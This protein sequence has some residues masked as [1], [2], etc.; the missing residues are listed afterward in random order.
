MC[1]ECI[2]LLR[3]FAEF[4]DMSAVAEIF[5]KKYVKNKALNKEQKTIEQSI[6]INEGR[7]VEQT[8]IESLHLGEDDLAFEYSSNELKTENV[9]SDI[10][11]NCM[12][13]LLNVDSAEMDSNTTT[14]VVDL[15]IERDYDISD[16]GENTIQITLQS[17][18]LSEIRCYRVFSQEV[19]KKAHDIT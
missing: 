8:Y 16:T 13:E 12:V 7:S 6:G 2:N 4:L 5:W 14:K 18:L 11:M 10:E 1:T 15:K 9:Y 19:K 17:N 3:E